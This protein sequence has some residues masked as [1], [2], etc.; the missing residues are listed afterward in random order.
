[1]DDARAL[2]EQ[3]FP[4]AVWAVVTGSVCVSAAPPSIAAL[5][6]FALVLGADVRSHRR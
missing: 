3:R 5:N 6:V 1:M 4:R 2:V